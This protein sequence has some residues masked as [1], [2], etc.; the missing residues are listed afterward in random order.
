MMLALGPWWCW[1]QDGDAEDAALRAE[2]GVN[3]QGVRW[4]SLRKGLSCVPRPL[5]VDP[6]G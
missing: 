1:E 6:P 5:E 4:E 2:K 3:D